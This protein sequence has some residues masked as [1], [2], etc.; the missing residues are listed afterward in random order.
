LEEKKKD[1]EAIQLLMRSIDFTPP[2]C[3][4]DGIMTFCSEEKEERKFID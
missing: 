2:H 1:M 3:L 4:L